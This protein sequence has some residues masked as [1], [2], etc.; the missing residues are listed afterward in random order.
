MG[1]GEKL[2]SLISETSSE[3]ARR[4]RSNAKSSILSIYLMRVRE[5]SEGTNV[6]RTNFQ[7][8]M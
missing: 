2:S 7:V 5:E 3:P 6:D 1:F 8:D 4:F